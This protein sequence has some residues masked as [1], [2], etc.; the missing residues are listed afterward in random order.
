MGVEHF[1]SRDTR[2]T[3]ATF[4]GPSP[5]IWSF[6]LDVDVLRFSLILAGVRQYCAHSLVTGFVR[7]ASGGFFG[8]FVHRVC[9]SPGDTC[10]YLCGA[11]PVVS[12]FGRSCS[13]IL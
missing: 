13:V 11:L 12:A 8:N 10:G 5:S 1:L 3:S 7:L 9:T 6:A 4:F 2:A